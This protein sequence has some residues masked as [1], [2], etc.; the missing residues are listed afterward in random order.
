[1]GDKRSME[2]DF[3]TKCG[4]HR[5]KTLCT[6]R[7]LWVSWNTWGLYVYQVLRYSQGSEFLVM[8]VALCW[9]VW[10]YVLM[11]LCRSQ[12]DATSLSNVVVLVCG[13]CALCWCSGPPKVWICS[14]LECMSN[15]VTQ[16]VPEL[17]WS[18]W[19]SLRLYC[20][21]VREAYASVFLRTKERQSL[22]TMDGI[23]RILLIN[24]SQSIDYSAGFFDT[25]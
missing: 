14:R 8:M 10:L 20:W 25:H 17:H 23:H 24:Y 13:Y 2:E 19:L 7:V 1:M 18:S 15:T 22:R 12:P 21:A 9:M 5:R 16:G 3:N 4:L 11:W 6:S